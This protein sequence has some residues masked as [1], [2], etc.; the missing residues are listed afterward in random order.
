LY[1]KSE[2]ILLEYVVQALSLPYLNS[3][4]GNKR[5][6]HPVRIII[7]QLTGL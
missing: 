7:K 1:G 5:Q 4:A 6:P 3:G 2:E